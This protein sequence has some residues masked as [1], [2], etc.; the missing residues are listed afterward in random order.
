LDD[1]EAEVTPYSKEKLKEFFENA[2]CANSAKK[3]FDRWWQ[4]KRSSGGKQTVNLKN[5]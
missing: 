3:H 2:F 1:L 5:S 4:E